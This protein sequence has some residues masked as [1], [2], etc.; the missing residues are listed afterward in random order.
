MLAMIPTTYGNPQVVE[1]IRRSGL[2]VWLHYTLMLVWIVVSLACGVGMLKGKNW[3]R[4]VYV[5]W[6][7]LGMTI[8]FTFTGIQLIVL[9]SIAL[10]VACA[11]LLFRQTANA[12]FTNQELI[13]DPALVTGSEAHAVPDALDTASTVREPVALKKLSTFRRVSSVLLLIVSGFTFYMATFL[14][15]IKPKGTPL[16]ITPLAIVCAIAFVFLLLGLAVSSFQ[17]WRLRSGIVLVSGCGVT[18]FVAAMLFCIRHSPQLLRDMPPESSESLDG[19]SNY[20]PGCSLLL[21]LLTVGILLILTNK[22]R[23]IAT[24]HPTESNSP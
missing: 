9:P 12:F 13:S 6:S 11:V 23:G 19:L 22:K 14:A 24:A 1:M 8:G 4:Y 15:F 20:V 17:K 7:I 18:V 21:P 16:P 10:L 3:S 2:P 5:T